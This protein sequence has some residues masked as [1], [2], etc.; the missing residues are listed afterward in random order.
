MVERPPL[1]AVIDDDQATL[2]ALGRVLGAEGY[3]SVPYSSAEDFLAA[4]P[5]RLPVC[6][7]LDLRLRQMSGLELQKRLRALDS[8]LPIVVMTAQH[9]D[10]LRSEALGLGCL[11]Y[12]DKCSD[13][14]DLLAVL[15]SLENTRQ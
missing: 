12:L 7:V 10:H 3:E 13:I 6:V 15:R 11:A 9:E 8:R 4:P 1:V 5:V 2:T 14:G